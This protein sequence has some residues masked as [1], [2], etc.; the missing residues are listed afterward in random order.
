MRAFES[1]SFSSSIQHFITKIKYT[2]R[3]EFV[4]KTTLYAFNL[5]QK[6]FFNRGLLRRLQTTRF[7][8]LDR[9]NKKGV[10]RQD[11]FSLVKNKQKPIER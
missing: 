2:N 11:V 6:Q 9:P 8:L 1:A 4:E 5:P 7:Y 3:H 10:S